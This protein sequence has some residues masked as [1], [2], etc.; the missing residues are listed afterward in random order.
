MTDPISW[1]T[2]ISAA[3][4]GHSI[5]DDNKRNAILKKIMLLIRS[6]RKI[7][8][9][10]LS[11]AGKSQFISSLKKNLAIAER[12]DTTE[13]IKF[14]IEDFPIQF[15]DTPGQAGR[16]YPRK[17]ELTEILKNGVEGI[18]NVVSYGYEEN[19]EFTFDDIFTPNK[20][21]KD[22]F[23]KL[24]RKSEVERLAEWLPLIHPNNIGWIINLVNK[25]DLWWDNLDAVNKHYLCEEYNEAFKQIDNY[26]N[27]I[28]IP[29]CSIIKPYYET[30]T[31]G[32]FGEL[33]KEQLYAHFMH[34]LHNLLKEE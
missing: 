4:A 14:N 29:F 10:G 15:I 21:V 33:H 7:V 11:G 23:L 34:Q 30:R 2:I 18:I 24:N 31:S 3:K 5:I 9:F 32:I 1:S 6:N 25:A 27:V 19:P 16:Q 26:S 22:S 20:E 12:T 28:T 13:K 17:Q 8:V